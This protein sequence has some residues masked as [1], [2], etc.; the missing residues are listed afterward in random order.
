MLPNSSPSHFIASCSSY[1]Q[2]SFP[3]EQFPHCQVLDFRVAEAP[4]L[5]LVNEYVRVFPGAL[6]FD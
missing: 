4:V 6:G 1:K 3:D 2:S 5:E